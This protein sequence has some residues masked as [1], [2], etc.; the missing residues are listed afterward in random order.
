MP[1]ASSHGRK[2]APSTPRARLAAE[3]HA[4]PP[5]P[6]AGAW[7]DASDSWLLLVCACWALRPLLVP[8]MVAPRAAADGCPVTHSLAPARALLACRLLP[9]SLAPLGSSAPRPGLVHQEPDWSCAAHAGQRSVGQIAPKKPMNGGCPTAAFTL[10]PIPAG[11]RHLVL[12][13]P[14]TEPS[15]RVVCLGSPRCARA[16]FRPGL[17]ALPLPSARSYSCPP[18]GQCR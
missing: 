11:F 16:S 15:M 14:G 17:A 7:M 10:S 18:R 3:A 2:P 8:A 1:V 9:R 13:H 4:A 5:L 12:T 6:R